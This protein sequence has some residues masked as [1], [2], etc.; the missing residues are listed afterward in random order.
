MT[1]PRSAAAPA[2]S[3]SRPTNSPAVRRSSSGDEEGRRSVRLRT[4][5]AS[6]RVAAD[7]T[8]PSVVRRR[9]RSSS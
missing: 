6:A 4:E 7:G 2:S 1:S 9:S 8:M 5:S 3:A